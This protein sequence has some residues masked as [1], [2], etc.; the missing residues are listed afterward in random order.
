MC[1]R[2]ILDWNYSW[3]DPGIQNFLLI[4]LNSQ[5]SIVE[6]LQNPVISMEHS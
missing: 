3:L 5:I 1:F 4:I 6:K 2:L